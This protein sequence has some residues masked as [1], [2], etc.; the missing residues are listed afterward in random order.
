MLYPI[1][2]KTIFKDKIWGGN[3]IHSILGKDFSPLPNCGETWEISGVPGNV[4]IVYNGA[5]S[6]KTLV[7]LIQQFKG[8]LI[9]NQIFEQFGENFP[10]L[11][12]FIDANEDLFH[13][14]MKLLEP[15]DFCANYLKL[16]SMVMP[17]LYV[18][19]H[20]AFQPKSPTNWEV[21]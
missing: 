8:E 6:G 13:A 4:S 5:L 9:G 7:E 2:F 11:I 19:P 18:A 16:L 3:K 20:T 12:K 15:K 14:K 10:L 17:P 1:K 21:D